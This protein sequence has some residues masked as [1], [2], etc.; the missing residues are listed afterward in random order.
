ME[1]PPPLSGLETIAPGLRNAEAKG[2]GARK[3]PVSGCSDLRWRFRGTVPSCKP[4]PSLRSDALPLAAAGTSATGGRPCGSEG[5][6]V[7]AEAGPDSS[8]GASGNRSTARLLADECLREG[9]LSWAIWHQGRKQDRKFS[10]G[11]K[12]KKKGIQ[13][14]GISQA[15]HR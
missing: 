14:G 8:W 13:Q 11:E 1:R 9:G 7:R 2:R 10:R 6:W 12:T 4:W 3:D 5:R 15:P